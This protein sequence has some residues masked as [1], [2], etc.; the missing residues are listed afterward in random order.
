MKPVVTSHTFMEPGMYQGITLN[1]EEIDGKRFTV[2]RHGPNSLPLL[3]R[4][5]T[6]FISTRL[7]GNRL[8]I[9]DGYRRKPRE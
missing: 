7:D 3:M 5:R 9:D 2:I 6:G 8:V 4:N 1:I